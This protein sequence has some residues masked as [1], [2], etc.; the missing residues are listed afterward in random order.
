[1]RSSRISL[2]R[3]IWFDVPSHVDGKPVSGDYLVS[4]RKN[5]K[6]GS[7]YL[8]IRAR[9]VKRRRP[10]PEFRRYALDVMKEAEITL[11]VLRAA[12]WF[13]RWRP[14]HRTVH[15]PVLFA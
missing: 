8:I 13:L 9:K 15:K 12:R 2:N 6:W 10:D 14:R 3:R 5:G 11:R 7:A 1:V 4:R